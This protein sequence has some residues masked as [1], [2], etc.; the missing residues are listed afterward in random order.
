MTPLDLD[1]LT[2]DELDAWQ[3]RAAIMQY[4]AGMTRE[5][6]EA[7]ALADVLAMR[8]GRPG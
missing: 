7:A 3:E 4:D 2:P 8:E 5:Q 1:Q 6:A